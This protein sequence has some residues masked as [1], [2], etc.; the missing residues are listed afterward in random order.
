[1]EEYPSD[2]DYKAIVE[3]K[4]GRDKAQAF[5][6]RH[7][8]VLV[9]TGKTEDLANV[10]RRM[11]LGYERTTSL[12]KDVLE[13]NKRKKA[14]AFI[15]ESEEDDENLMEDLESGIKRGYQYNENKELEVQSVTRTEE[16]FDINLQYQDRNPSRR[17]L[18]STQSR[19]ITVSLTQTDQDDIRKG[20]QEYRYA[21]EFN[22]ASDFFEEWR[23][24]R[25]KERK[26]QIKRV[27][28]NIERVSPED[29]V[30]LFNNFLQNPPEDWRFE[31]V[32]ELGI[33][34]S[35]E[36]GDVIE[37]EEAE[38]E[39]EEEIEVELDE[40]LRGITDAVFKGTGL[41]ENQFVQD[42]LESG[43]YFNSVRA[44]FD[45]TDS[46]DSI[47]LELQFKQ[48]PKTTFDLSIVE[49]KERVED[50]D[51]PGNLGSDKREETRN[52]FRSSVV[53]LYGEYTDQSAL[54]DDEYADSL[55]DIHGIS[56]DIADRLESR[57]IESPK[58]LFESDPAPLQ[59]VEGIGKT[60][61]ERY[62][63]ESD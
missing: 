51:A 29:S 34:Q 63:G 58:E 36:T 2:Q 44:R 22:A 3:E 18:Q 10:T 32:L 11:Y 40:N 35:G 55:T 37:E 38:F 23:A 25:L 9:H 52:L 62:A 5:L 53:D 56:E 4:Y 48:R 42:C 15:F 7:T 30:E 20:T 43:F 1:M 16:G 8:H 31:Q 61:A 46:T 41:R 47:E 24:K 6:R 21:D 27:N 26:S 33:K 59:E 45:D 57:G 54:I 14:T 19:S 12:K 60:K 50:G 17:P 39:G 49:E 28:F 13:K